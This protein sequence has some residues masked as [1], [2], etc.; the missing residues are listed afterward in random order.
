MFDISLDSVCYVIAQAR[1]LALGRDADDEGH[2]PDGHGH[3]DLIHGDTDDG[4]WSSTPPRQK[5]FV[6]FLNATWN[7]KV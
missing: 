1:T 5:P 3:E 4:G 6:T 7:S 2:D